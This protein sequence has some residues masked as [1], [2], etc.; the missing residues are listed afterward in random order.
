MHLY[1]FLV[2]SLEFSDLKT[3]ENELTQTI[4]Y[5][6]TCNDLKLNSEMLILI[7]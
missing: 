7:K 3:M 4:V 5:R 6:I 1:L 2:K